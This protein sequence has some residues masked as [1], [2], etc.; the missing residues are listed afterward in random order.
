MTRRRLSIGGQSFGSARRASARRGFPATLRVTCVE[1]KLD[2][3]AEA[4]PHNQMHGPRRSAPN[5]TWGRPS[6]LQR[7]ASARRR[8]PAMLRVTCVEQKLD[9]GAEAPPHGR[10]RPK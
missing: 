6:A 3:G 8:F 10:N 1:Q 7:R 4:P 5:L 9:G 2:G